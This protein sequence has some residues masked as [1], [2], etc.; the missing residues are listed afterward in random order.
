MYRISSTIDLENKILTREI[1]LH[2][3]PI[4]HD[5]PGG[6]FYFVG[7][8]TFTGRVKQSL[9]QTGYRLI[10]QMP[11][12]AELDDPGGAMDSQ[13]EGDQDILA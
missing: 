5:T 11:Q 7:A 12:D 10:A 6:G 9:W 2:R 4:F 13:A 1:A 8:N 3:D